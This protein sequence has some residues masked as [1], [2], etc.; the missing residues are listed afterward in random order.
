MSLDP[1][2]SIVRE[3]FAQAQHV[4]VVENGAIGYFEDQGMRIRLSAEVADGRLRKLRFQ[5][6]GCPH[7]VAASEAFCRQFEGRP[8]MDLEQFKTAPI[9]RDLA[10]PIEKTGRILV[11]EDTVRSLGQAIQDQT[12]QN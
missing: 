11:L 10:V 7:V 1:Y 3:C 9:M 5:A 4:G 2:N 12:L 8:A 6:W